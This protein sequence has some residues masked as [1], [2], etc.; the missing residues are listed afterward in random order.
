MIDI[1]SFSL[2]F[3]ILC[4]CTTASKKE[5]RGTQY[6]KTCKYEEKNL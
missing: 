1:G 6:E 2:G 5:R 4:T 3:M